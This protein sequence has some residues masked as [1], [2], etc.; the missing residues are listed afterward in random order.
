LLSEL[1]RER[2]VGVVR[3]EAGRNGDFLHLRLLEPDYAV[4]G[5]HRER[6]VVALQLRESVYLIRPVAELVYILDGR[7]VAQ[8]PHLGEVARG[9]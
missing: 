5:E 3:I 1:W 7:K 4:V 6:Y 2:S 8:P 9:D